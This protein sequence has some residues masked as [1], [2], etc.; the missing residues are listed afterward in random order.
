MLDCSWSG[1]TLLRVPPRLLLRSR[2]ARSGLPGIGVPPLCRNSRRSGAAVSSEPRVRCRQRLAR[3]R[4]ETSRPVWPASWLGR[5]PEGSRWGHWAACASCDAMPT[6]TP[7]SA[8]RPLAAR[9]A[10]ARS[11]ALRSRPQAPR[12]TPALT[13]RGRSPVRVL[14]ALRALRPR[15]SAWPHPPRRPTRLDSLDSRRA[16]S[17]RHRRPRSCAPSEAAA[18]P[19]TRPGRPSPAGATSAPLR[20]TADRAPAGSVAASRACRSAASVAPRVRPVTQDPRAGLRPE[21]LR[22]SHGAPRQRPNRDS[23]PRSG[24]APA[25]PRRLAGA[26]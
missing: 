21:E 1:A 11:E 3:L 6:R 17:V 22:N 25:P 14:V 10:L 23:R 7:V 24:Q 13:R 5:S 18:L 9:P 16:S 2:R 8:A 26:R 4:A 15:R 20:R 12:R 19:V